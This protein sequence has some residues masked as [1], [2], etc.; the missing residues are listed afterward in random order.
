M[1]VGGPTFLAPQKGGFGASAGIE[2]LWR[3][4]FCSYCPAFGTGRYNFSRRV[5]R[6]K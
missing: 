3:A 6:C 1:E 5:Q 2:A 4:R